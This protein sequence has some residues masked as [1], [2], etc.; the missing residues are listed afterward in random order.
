MASIE[1][2][3]SAV[4]HGKRK[5]ALPLVQQALDEGVSPQEILSNGLIAAMDVIG[6][7]FSRNEVF[8]PEM[9]MAAR[10]MQACTDQ[11]KPLLAEAG[12]VQALGNGVIGTVQGDMH[13][14]G[15]NLVKL[16]VESK[17]FELEDLGVD[18][19]AEAFAE[20]VKAHPECKFMFLS[21]LLTTTMP[22]MAATVKAIEE[23]GLR[24]QVKIFVGGAPVTREFAEEIGADYYTDDAGECAATAAAVATGEAA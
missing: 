1:E 20:Y 22:A 12:G 8:V 16:L 14:I 7:K 2:I 10:T 24:D 17:G 15:K 11:L 6:E 4:E 13:D 19:A 18:V 9:L 3:A 5:E 21:S 23:A